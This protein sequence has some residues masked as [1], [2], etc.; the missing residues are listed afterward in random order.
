MFAAKRTFIHPQWNGDFL[1]GNDIALIQLDRASDFP[2]PDLATQGSL[3]T[4]GSVFSALGWGRN[5][6]GSFTDLLQ[7]AT[8]LPFVAR[9]ICN[10]NN[11]WSGQIKESM[12]CAG[13]GEQDTQQGD[14]FH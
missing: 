9:G 3:Y 4:S 14:A 1:E 10:R 8:R 5:S 11:Y 6:S 2:H 7:I 12:I 13:V